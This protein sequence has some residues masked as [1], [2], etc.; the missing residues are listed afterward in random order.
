MGRTLPSITQ[1]FMQEQQSFNRFR[2]ALRRK[3]QYALDGLFAHARLH[4]AAA[5]YAAHA[6]PM[7]IML[8]AMLLEHEKRLDAIFFATL[9]DGEYP[10]PDEEDL[11]DLID[12]DEEPGEVASGDIF[13]WIDAQTGDPPP[14]EPLA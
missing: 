12:P 10:D 7:E 14:D 4:I 9:A 8:L 1:Q 11:D 2:R 5:G 3:D 6:L 13:D